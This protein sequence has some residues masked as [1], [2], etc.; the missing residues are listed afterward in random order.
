MR[1]K[2]HFGNRL[3]NLGRGHGALW[4]A[5][6]SGL[7]Q[8][9]PNEPLLHECSYHDVDPIGWTKN[10][11]FLIW[12]GG[13]IRT[14]ARRPP[15]IPDLHRRSGSIPGEPYPPSKRFDCTAGA[16]S[17][18]A[19]TSILKKSAKSRGL[20]GVAPIMKV[21]SSFLLCAGTDL[22]ASDSRAPGAAARD[23]KSGSSLP[24]PE[25]VWG[26]WRS[27]EDKLARTS[28]SAIGVR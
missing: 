14:A 23:C 12:S 5:P 20:G 24:T 7:P 6:N 8:G 19:K 18:K 4:A 26:R 17:S 15:S 10:R 13:L 22:P 11:P 28:K 16:V 9:C 3:E 1:K 2:A 27:R 25:T 21:T